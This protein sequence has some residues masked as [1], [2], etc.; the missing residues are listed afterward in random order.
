MMLLAFFHGEGILFSFL[1]QSFLAGL[2]IAGLSYG[3]AKFKSWP[4]VTIAVGYAA[5]T[6]VITSLSRNRGN[7]GL[8]TAGW[9]LT[10][11]WNAIVPCYNLDRSCP[12]TLAVSLI[13][14]ELNAAIVYFLVVW[15]S[16]SR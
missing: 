8:E 12:L 11:P 16:R 15:F 2:G 5:V 9:G 7:V 1:I 10:L 13:C 3:L 6:L 14:V 4:G